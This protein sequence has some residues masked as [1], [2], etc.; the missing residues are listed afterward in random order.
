MGEKDDRNIASKINLRF[1]GFRFQNA[2]PFVCRSGSFE[3]IERLSTRILI[4]SDHLKEYK[5]DH[6]AKRGLSVIIGRRTKLLKYLEGKDK[7]A[8]F[9]V[10]SKVGVKT[11]TRANI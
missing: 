2:A 8:Y 11:S 4:L 9:E 1:Q 6:S 7:S 5:Q 3:Q 10:C